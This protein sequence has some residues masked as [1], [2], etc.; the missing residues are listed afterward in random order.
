MTTHSR[1]RRA[2][3]PTWGVNSSDIRRRTTVAPDAADFPK[4]RGRTKIITE[5]GRGSQTVWASL[6][7]CAPQRGP[8]LFHFI[9]HLPRGPAYS[10]PPPQSVDMVLFLVNPVNC[11][12]YIYF[13][14]HDGHRLLASHVQTPKQEV[15][16]TD[17]RL[18][19]ISAR[20]T[21]LAN[22]AYA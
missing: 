3:S 9:F 18:K 2:P 16:H 6:C 4:E 5:R 1:A 15:V 17:E 22:R 7:M 14:H 13:D 12:M 19:S 11:P 21:R 10:Q 20:L 8:F